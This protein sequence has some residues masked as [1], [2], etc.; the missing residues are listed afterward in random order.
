MSQN[1]IRVHRPDLTPEER[2]K[3]MER[4]KEAAIRLLVAYEKERQK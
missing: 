1:I 2:A 4:I 3:R